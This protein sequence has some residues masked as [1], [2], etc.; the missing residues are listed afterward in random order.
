MSRRI[1]IVQL[2]HLDGPGGGPRSLI[3]H[4]LF[5][6][7]ESDSTILHGGSGLVAR[8]CERIGIPHHRVLLERKRWLV[9]G[10]FQVLV[11]LFQIRPDLL[12][13]HGQW[14]GP[15]GAVA[16]RLAGVRAILY[17]VQWPSFYTDWDPGRILRNILAEWI[18]CRLATRVVTL[19]E[20]P[21]Y[22]FL[23]R[24]LAAPAKILSIPNPLSQGVVPT[25]EDRNELRAEWGWKPDQVHVVSVGRLV[26]QKRVDWLLQAWPEV[27]R[28]CP[29]ARLWVVGEGPER[30]KL[31]TLAAKMALGSTVRFLGEQPNGWKFLA[32]ADVVVMT[33]AYEGLGNV[34]AEA[35]AAGV[36]VLASD[37]D[38]PRDILADG[39]QG[40]LVPPGDVAGLAARLG[41]L[42]AS[43]ELRVAMGKRGLEKAKEFDGNHVLRQYWKVIQDLVADPPA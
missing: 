43:R 36:P 41:D 27:S 25:I 24:G 28:R 11:R 23:L 3:K 40:F 20:G 17:I 18:P 2:T 13:L 5:Y 14:A 38:G 6:L 34:V 8:M 30:K 9:F 35:M 33:T 19:C 16:G 22:Q 42:V 15:V 12:I 1:R 32:A 4:M 26:D 37:A 29:Q 31:E 7:A 39:Q 21:R 10:F